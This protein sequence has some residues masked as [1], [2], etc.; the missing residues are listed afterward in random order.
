MWIGGFLIVGAGAH[1]SIYMVRDYD[2]EFADNNLLDRVLIHRDSIVAHLTWV[3]LFLGFH[4][5]GL[6]IHNDTLEAL[7]RLD[8]TFSDEAISLKPIFA[9]FIQDLHTNYLD[10]TAPNSL[11]TASYIFGGGIVYVDNVI[12]I[13]P[14]GLGTSDFM[15]HHIHAFNIHVTVLILLKGTLYARNSSLVPDKKNGGFVFPCDGPGRGGT[16]QVSAWDHVFLSLFWMYNTISLVIFH[17]SWEMQSDVW[18]SISDQGVIEHIVEESGFGG[19]LSVETWLRDYLWLQSNSVIESYGTAFSAYGLIFL[20][21][22]FIWAFSL[23]F[24][25]SGRGYWQELIESILWAHGKL[26]VAP[27]IQPRA[28][29]ITQGRAVGVAHFLLGGIGTTW[30]FFLARILDYNI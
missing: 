17:F 28:L 23:M 30:A 11:A 12:S 4:S 14:I 24:L 18:G 26:R 7:G 27:F 16:C 19:A 13:M 10:V 2:L 5:F 21:A 22:H 3:C 9:S 15:I 25:F 20:G 8:D 1:A 6:Y 29:S